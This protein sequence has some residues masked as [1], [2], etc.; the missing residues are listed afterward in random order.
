MYRLYLYNRVEGKHS[1]QK[2]NKVLGRTPCFLEKY[3]KL[4]NDR[5]YEWDY[6][7][8]HELINNSYSK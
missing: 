8:Y 6:S 4:L 5:G 1:W 2:M 7:L 3:E